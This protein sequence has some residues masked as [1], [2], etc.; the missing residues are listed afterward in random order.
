VQEGHQFKTR[1][2]DRSLALIESAAVI[3]DPDL[4]VEIPV[5]RFQLVEADFAQILRC[6]ATHRVRTLDGSKVQDVISQL[7]QSDPGAQEST[8][9][10]L[11]EQMA[12]AWRE[13]TA[14]SEACRIVAL[15]ALQGTFEEAGS[16]LLRESFYYVLNPCILDHEAPDDLAA[17]HCSNRLVVTRDLQLTDTQGDLDA[18][19]REQTFEALSAYS[20]ARSRTEGLATQ[21]RVLAGRGE[22]LIPI[23]QK[24][25]RR[26]QALTVLWQGLGHLANIG[27]GAAIAQ[28]PGLLAVPIIQGEVRKA[29]AALFARPSEV[30]PACTALAQVLDDTKEVGQQHG[31]SLAELERQAG[32][33]AS[34]RTQGGN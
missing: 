31:I 20:A 14:A 19:K 22:R 11:K 2:S 29:V 10:A 34:L 23:C 15:R 28:A 30:P 26:E 33:I 9:D 16:N 17:A 18:E 32:V 13:A 1:P 25:H 6:K 3:A 12:W 24:Q 27:V 7:S 21:L 8:R 4:R 5:V